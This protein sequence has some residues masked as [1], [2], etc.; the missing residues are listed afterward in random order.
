MKRIVFIGEGR[1]KSWLRGKAN[2]IHESIKLMNEFVA[3]PLEHS[4]LSDWNGMNKS[5]YWF[6]NEMEERRGPLAA[7]ELEE[8]AQLISSMGWLWAGGSSAASAFRFIENISIPLQPSCLFLSLIKRRL[9]R[10]SIQKIVKSNNSTW[11]RLIDGQSRKSIECIELVWL[12]GGAPRQR[13][14]AVNLIGEWMIMNE[15]N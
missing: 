3:G 7:V 12:S 4:K 13:G 1:I 5:I 9:A 11:M 10:L 8:K 2:N 15:D 6:M 14:S